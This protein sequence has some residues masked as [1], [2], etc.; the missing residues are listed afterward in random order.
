MWLFF[1]VFV[2]CLLKFRFIVF[3]F[4]SCSGFSG[5]MVFDGASQLMLVACGSGHLIFFKLYRE[6]VVDIVGARRPT[7]VQAESSNVS[8]HVPMSMQ[9]M[10][11]CQ[12]ASFEIGESVW[13]DMNTLRVR[14]KAHV[15]VETF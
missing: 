9:L 4:L 5:G 12:A 14:W 6:T 7:E 3:V 10:A 15:V 1:Q 11:V 2:Q 13:H 8:K